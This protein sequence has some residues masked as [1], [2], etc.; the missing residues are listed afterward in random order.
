MTELLHVRE[1]TTLFQTGERTD[2]S[3]PLMA[4]SATPSQNNNEGRKAKGGRL[5]CN[6]TQQQK[7]LTALEEE[8]NVGA[9]RGQADL[10]TLGY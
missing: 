4:R 3:Q 6:V 2:L 1:D 10:Q 7:Q 9:Q 8:P 5:R